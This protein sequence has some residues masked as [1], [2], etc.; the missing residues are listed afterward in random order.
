[1]APARYKYLVTDAAAAADSMFFTIE[2]I[3]SPL[4]S[5]AQDVLPQDVVLHSNYP[6]P[7]VG[8]TRIMLDLPEAAEVTVTVMD[9]L[10]RTVQQTDAG[11]LPAGKHHEIAVDGRSLSAGAYPYRVVVRTGNKSSIR[12]G[13]M[14]RMQ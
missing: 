9:M 5:D 11:R 10:G 4:S 3:S 13:V 12:A 1:M 8:T 7:F 6:N 14:I 2:V